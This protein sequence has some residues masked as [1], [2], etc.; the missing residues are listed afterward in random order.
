MVHHFLSNSGLYILFFHLYYII[1][2][3]NINRSGNITHLSVCDSDLLFKMIYGTTI[4]LYLTD[5]I[6]RLE[7]IPAEKPLKRQKVQITH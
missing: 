3:G 7:R 2:E 1:I 6:V 4:K 5:G